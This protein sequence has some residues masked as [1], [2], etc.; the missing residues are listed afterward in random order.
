MKISATQTWRTV[1]MRQVLSCGT[2][3]PDE[4]R[5]SVGRRLRTNQE[6]AIIIILKV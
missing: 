3:H 2:L 4:P 5:P 6:D 1:F